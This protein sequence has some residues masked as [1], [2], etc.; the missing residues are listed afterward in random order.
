M[1]RL[2]KWLGWPEWYS[3][4]KERW[5]CVRVQKPVA[6]FVRELEQFDMNSGR[7]RWVAPSM[8]AEK[9]M[10]E[11]VGVVVGEIVSSKYDL[12][13]T[14]CDVAERFYML[15]GRDASDA[16]LDAEIAAL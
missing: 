3:T 13:R 7:Y 16:E 4:G 9:W 12:Q 14:R 1:R 5:R 6:E 11:R 10:G 8:F 15:H 2:W